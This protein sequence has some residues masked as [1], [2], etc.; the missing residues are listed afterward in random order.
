[1][2]TPPIGE[3]P[4]FGWGSTSVLCVWLLRGDHNGVNELMV[5]ICLP[6]GG[7]QVVSNDNDNH[8][9]HDSPQNNMRFSKCGGFI[10]PSSL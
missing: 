7:G 5:G 10:E 8:D 2:W 3:A 4:E 1:M 6:M 9:S